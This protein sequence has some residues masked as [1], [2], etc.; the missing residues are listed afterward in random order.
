MMSEVDI[1]N[2]VTTKDAQTYLGVRRESITKWIGTHNLPAYKVGRVWKFKLSEIDEWVC[3]GQAA[4]KRPLKLLTS[5]RR[6][7][8][9]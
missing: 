5:R 9:A 3:T 6:N 8:D 2:W 1:E 7:A 4:K